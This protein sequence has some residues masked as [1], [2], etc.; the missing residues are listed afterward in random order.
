[1]K[2]RVKSDQPKSDQRGAA[3]VEFALTALVLYLVIAGGTELGRM[4]F[5][6]QVLQDAARAAA[7][8]LAVTPLPADVGFEEALSD[9]LVKAQIWDPDKL[10]VDLDNTEGLS[11]DQLFASLPLVNQA[12][13]PVF[14]PDTVSVGGEVHRVLRY[15]ASQCPNPDSPT[16][17]EVGIPRVTGRDAEGVE[18]V[19]CLPVLSEIRV[20]PTDPTCARYGPFNAVR[21]EACPNAVP[22]GIAA[23]QITYPFQSGALSAFQNTGVDTKGAPNPNVG[24]VIV[25]TDPEDTPFGAY[26]GPAGLGSQAA[27]GQVVRPYRNLLVGQSMFRREVFQ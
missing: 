27:M 5:V 4:V 20:V 17:F 14:I 16:G 24:N 1:M 18:F 13:R 2:R 11:A 8:E 26:T 25:S 12:L 10:I 3:L 21:S 19:E 22:P 9:V 23:V 7:R 6:S 15:P